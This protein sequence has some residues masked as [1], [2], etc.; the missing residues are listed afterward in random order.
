MTQTRPMK[1][2]FVGEGG[3]LP[4]GAG[5]GRPGLAS[6]EATRNLTHRPSTARSALECG[7]SAPL[8]LTRVAMLNLAL[9]T[10]NPATRVCQSS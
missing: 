8:S 3:A 1:S 7:A 9:E 10:P 6:T 4:Q 5:I 2:A